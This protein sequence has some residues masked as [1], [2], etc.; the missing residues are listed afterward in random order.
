MAIHGVQAGRRWARL[1][2]SFAYGYAILCLGCYASYRGA[3]AATVVAIAALLTL[4]NVV[5]KKPQHVSP[6]EFGAHL[7][8]A[9]FFALFAHAVGWG[10]GRAIGV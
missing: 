1:D 7:V 4:P 6:I 5:K 8:V 9:F 2:W 10:I 3:P